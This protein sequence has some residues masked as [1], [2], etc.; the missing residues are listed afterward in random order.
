MEKASLRS[1]TNSIVKTTCD[2]KGHGCAGSLTGIYSS[3]VLLCRQAGSSGAAQPRQVVM[4]TS[5]TPVKAAGIR[6]APAGQWWWS[7]GRTS[8]QL[9]VPWVST[10]EA[11]D[12]A[13]LFRATLQLCMVSWA[14]LL[15]GGSFSR[16]SC[17]WTRAAPLLAALA[18]GQLVSFL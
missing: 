9:C 3:Q 5:A 7:G 15:G 18:A 14:V 2:H 11:P 6:A 12:A 17:V 10:H 13:Q 16:C 8:S 4:N 1:A